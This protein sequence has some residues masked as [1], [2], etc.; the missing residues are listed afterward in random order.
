M[1]ILAINGS[2]RG[3]KGCTQLLLDVRRDVAVRY[4]GADGC[5]TTARG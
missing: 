5:R 2:H 3:K 4:R 1:K